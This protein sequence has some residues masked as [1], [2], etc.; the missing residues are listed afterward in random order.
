MHSFLVRCGLSLKSDTKKDSRI[1]K[2]QKQKGISM[3]VKN[4]RT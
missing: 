3:K 4:K 2:S 1:Q